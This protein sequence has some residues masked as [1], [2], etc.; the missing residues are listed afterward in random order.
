MILVARFEDLDIMRIML[1]VSIKRNVTNV[2]C[3]NKEQQ[4]R[5]A[6]AIPSGDKVESCLGEHTHSKV[7]NSV[8]W[9]K[10][11]DFPMMNLKSDKLF[12]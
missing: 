10:V 12:F 3:R 7:N 6:Y 4:L 9:L 2:P 5:L 11:G 1:S 8:T